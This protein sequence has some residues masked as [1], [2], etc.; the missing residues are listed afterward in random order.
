VQAEVKAMADLTH[1]CVVDLRE[2]LSNHESIFMIMQYCP[3]G[4]MYDIVRRRGAFSEDEAR[5]HFQR[6]I[7]GVA[8]CHSKRIYHRDLKPENLFLDENG[9][10]C[11]GDFGLAA[12]KTDSEDT[13]LRTICGTP[14]FAAPEVMGGSKR[15]VGNQNFKTVNQHTRTVGYE[16]AAADVWSCGC[17]LYFFLVGSFPFDGDNFVQLQIMVQKTEPYFPRLPNGQ[18]KVSERAEKL[19]RAMMVKDPAGRIKL[20]RVM[21]DPWFR[22]NFVPVRVPKSPSS[23][24]FDEEDPANETD[25]FAVRDDLVVSTDDVGNDMSRSET[26]S[27]PLRQLN[28]FE[29]INMTAFD[30]ANIFDSD[31]NT[32]TNATR[33]VTSKPPNDVQK[34]VIAAAKKLGYK[35]QRQTNARVVFE[36]EKHALYVTMRV[37]QVVP[38]ICLF[39]FSRDSGSRVTF[40]QWF[41]DIH[42]DETVLAMIAKSNV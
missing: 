40:H 38:G 35:A 5:R 42:A 41:D 20:D 10:L 23:R 4:E 3:N 16:G 21:K 37:Y 31:E 34:A 2:V 27:K 29:L 9:D 24:H 33:F 13:N 39:D 17:I 22:V 36:Q 25:I 18:P 32:V 15:L 7:Q 11:I 26:A 1:P 8:F 6:L 30:I 19:I 12:L 14:H 28:A